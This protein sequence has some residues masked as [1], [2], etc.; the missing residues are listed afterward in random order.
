[1][2][3]MSALANKLESHNARER[4]VYLQSPLTSTSWDG[5]SF[6]TTAKTAIDLSAAFGVPAG[7]KAILVTI[8]ARDSASASA[9][10][11]CQCGLAPNNTPGQFMLLCKIYDRPNDDLE[12]VTSEVPCNIDGDV[13]FQCTAS[14][15]GT[16]DVWIEIWGYYI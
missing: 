1:M 5:D 9:T 12:Y 16:L 6:S 2:S 8:A 7:A 10:P 13:Y 15:A 3:R 11:K 14:G 4:W